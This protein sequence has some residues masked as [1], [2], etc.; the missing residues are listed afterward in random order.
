M[1]HNDGVKPSMPANRGGRWDEHPLIHPTADGLGADLQPLS[2][3]GWSEFF[4]LC[5]GCHSC[6]LCWLRFTFDQRNIP[7]TFRGKSRE[8]SVSSPDTVRSQSALFSSNSPFRRCTADETRLCTKSK[9]RPPR[10]RGHVNHT[11][12]TGKRILMPSLLWD[13]RKA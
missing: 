9:N 1:F 10:F 7:S 13:C 12:T 2:H 5:C 11:G 8:R 6:A 3:F 4:G